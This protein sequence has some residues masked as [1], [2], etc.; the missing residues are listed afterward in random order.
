MKEV[1]FL[2][3]NRKRWQEFEQLLDERQRSNPDQLADLFVQLTDDLAYARTYYPTS[4][5]VQ[6]LNGLT[7]RVHQA[8]YR[9]RKVRGNQFIRFWTHD[10]PLAVHGAHR[11]ILYSLIIFLTT[12]LIGVISTAHDPEFPRSILSSEYVDETLHNIDKGKPMDIYGSGPETTS[13]LGIALNNLYVMLLTIAFGLL[14]SLGSVY[15][16]L[17]NGVM[18]GVFQFF[19]IQRGLGVDSALVIWIHGTLEISA[20]II[21]GGAGIALG[22]SILFPRTYSRKD[23]LMIGAKKAVMIFC[24]LVPVIITAALLE[25]FVTRHTEMPVLGSLGIIGASLLFIIWYFVLYPIVVARNLSDAP[26]AEA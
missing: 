16:V 24:G 23:S 9:N 12:A 20:L 25:G 4:N 15:M 17:R 19:F 13:F 2:Q 10:L 22:N 26:H 11:E 5:T 3:Q 1:A 14:V 21:A 6:Y 8:I 7:A 18:V